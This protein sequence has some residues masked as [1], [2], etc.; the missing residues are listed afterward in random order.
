M[1]AAES[2]MLDALQWWVHVFEYV[3][4]LCGDFSTAAPH[5]FSNYHPLS[6]KCK[7]VYNK[8]LIKLSYNS[9]DLFNL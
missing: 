3:S 9:F 1:G 8:H 2:F 4:T 5:S 6:V 7:P